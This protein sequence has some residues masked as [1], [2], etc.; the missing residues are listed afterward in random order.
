MKSGLANAFRRK[1]NLNTQLAAA[2]E[3]V[4]ADKLSGEWEQ[5]SIDV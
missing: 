2:R 4:G 1:P 5:H 3:S